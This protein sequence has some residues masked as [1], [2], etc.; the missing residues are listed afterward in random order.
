MIQL[1]LTI[2]PESLTITPE[3]LIDYYLKLSDI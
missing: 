3:S 2:T 1:V